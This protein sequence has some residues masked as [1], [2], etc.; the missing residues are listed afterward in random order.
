MT[1]LPPLNALRAFE[2][3]AR[4]LSFTRAA[5]ELSVTQAAVSHQIKTLEERLGVRLFQRRNRA[6]LLTAEGQ[7][8]YPDVQR[9][10]ALLGEA[11]AKL[12]AA[13]NRGVLTLSTLP[14]FAARW[15]VPRLGGFIDRHPEIDLRLATTQRLVDFAR[16]QVDAAI[17]YGSGRY[18]GLSV[19]LLLTEEIF[20]V[21]SPALL[22][23]IPL[24]CPQDLRKHK[25]LHD[26]G[27]DEWDRW[28]EAARV[29]GIDSAH[30]YWYRDSSL[31][32]QA[33][34]AGQG[35]ALGRSVLAADDLA[36]GRLVRP[37]S[38]ALPSTNAY[39]FVCPEGSAQRGKIAAF[40]D[41]VL[42]EAAA[43]AAESMGN[44]VSGDEQS[45]AA[46]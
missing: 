27:V 2:A 13:D 22:A 14:S 39:Y 6:L 28:L 17:R 42:A 41:W 4:H 16:D 11:T 26:H 12:T 25:L 46:G 38:L 5:E 15:L 44:R 21:C 36:A 3:A 10:F 23:R 1:R 35:V 33:A 8:Y 32:L 30:G 45:I 7:L 18:P 9:A 19:T 37:F 31:L 24:A 29:P 20:P 43:P 40:S 34:V